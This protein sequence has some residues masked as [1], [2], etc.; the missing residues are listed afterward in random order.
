VFR[1]ATKNKRVSKIS[2]YC[3]IK[4]SGKQT[5]LLPIL[6]AKAQLDAAKLNLTYTA[7]TAAIDGQ[8]P[9]LIFSQDSTG[10]VLF[11][12]INNKEAWVMLISKKLN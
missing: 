2:Y 12:I 1:A 7:V 5:E 10:T 6:K 11:Y 4:V 3:Q 8:V 9:K